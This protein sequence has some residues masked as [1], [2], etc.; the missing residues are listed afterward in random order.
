MC[1]DG[2]P[3]SAEAEAAE[4]VHQ[5]ISREWTAVIEPLLPLADQLAGKLIDPHDPQLR[6][7]Y[8]QAIVSQLAGGYLALF[9]PD[10]RHPDFWPY[11]ATGLR[12]TLNNPDTNY[13]LTPIEDGGIYQLSGFR[14]TVHKMDA[15]IGSGSWL[16]RGELAGMQTEAVTYDFSDDL[17]SRSDGAFEVI[18][19]KRRPM[20]HD[21]D[22][23]ELPAGATYVL[24]RNVSYDWAT[25]V[26]GR[27]AIDRLD[28]PA[29]RPRRTAGELRAELAQLGVWVHGNVTATLDFA[30]LARNGRTNRLEN[31]TLDVSDNGFFGKPH[32]FYVYGAFELDPDEALLIEADVPEDVRYWNIQLGDDLS[33]SQDW[34]SRQTTLNGFTAH[35]DDDRVFRVVIAAQDPGVPN[36]LDTMGYRSGTLC[37]RWEGCSAPPAEYRARVGKV[38]DIRH[39]L[40]PGTPAVNARQRDA[41]IRRRRRGVQLRKR[42]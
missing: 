22:W 38:A 13:L 32:Q 19:S 26:D 10:P 11:T 3:L 9:S 18:L 24:V 36:W 4:G 17:H 7:E 41:E 42:W 40:P 23:W 14:G 12:A 21:G 37:A 6:Y 5:V 2:A 33:F 35:L 20:G 29:Q 25:E 34:M 39:F 27:V 28:T 15:M 31:L 1:S 16:T 8:Y 30:E